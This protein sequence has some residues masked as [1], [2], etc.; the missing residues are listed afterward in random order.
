MVTE[1]RQVPN[2]TLEQA[3]I[4]AAYNSKARN[5]SK[6]AV[7]YT[8]IRNVKKQPG[9]KPGMVIYEPYSTAIVDPDEQLVNSLEEK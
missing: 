6:V 1:G 5:S 2:S 3:A 4:I 9:G 8:E 7:D